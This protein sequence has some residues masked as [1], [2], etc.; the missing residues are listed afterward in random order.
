[1]ATENHA[2]SSFLCRRSWAA[3]AQDAGFVTALL[4]NEHCRITVHRHIA[5]GFCPRR[6]CHAFLFDG[7][8]C[9]WK[10]DATGVGI[11]NGTVTVVAS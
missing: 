3:R 11:G 5:V 8:L 10:D 9:P 2:W 4:V 7:E 6:Q 1:M